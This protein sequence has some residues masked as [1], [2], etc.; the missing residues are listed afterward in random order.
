MKKAGKL[1]RTILLLAAVGIAALQPLK[2][3]QAETEA[4]EVQEEAAEDALDI[5]SPSALLMEASTGTVLYEKDAHTRRSPASVTKIM[6]TL[7]IFEALEKGG[8]KLEDEVVTSAYAKSMGGSQVFLEEGEKQTVNTL[9]KCILVSSGNDA[10]VAMA[11]HIAGTEA[12]FVNR[13][14][15]K[16]GE[17]GMKDTH[18]EDCCGLTDSE[19][20]YTT[21]YDIALMSRELI[22]RYPQVYDYTTIWMDTITHVTR[23]GSSEFG[24]SNT[25]KLLRSYDG[26]RGLKTGSTSKALFCVSATAVRNE[27]ELISV[28]MAGPDS[29]TRFA[30]AASLLN[31]GFGK[32]RIYIDSEPP[33]LPKLNVRNGVEETVACRYAG[34]FRYLDTEGKNLDAIERRLEL[35]QE[36]KAPVEK[37]AVAGRIVYLLDGR[38]IG[39]EDILFDAAVEKAGYTHYLKKAWEAYCV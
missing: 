5:A 18:F 20:H 17:L 33:V 15:Q 24:L 25:N 32:C 34:E 11:E 2:A 30:N 10:S 16:A 19:N 8:L 12:E 3:V 22:T 36:V 4:S 1:R 37:G 6:T 31:Y 14:N 29:K 27:V 39:T 21:A 13:M 9:L 28:I 23:Q 35:N 38:E 26:C 7:L